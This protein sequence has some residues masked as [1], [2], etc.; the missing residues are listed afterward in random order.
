[1]TTFVDSSAFYAAADAGDRSHARAKSVLGAGER[2]LTSDHVLIET[3]FLIRA[4]GGRRAAE[5]FWREIRGGLAVV[6][7]VLPRD[8]DLAFLIGE[9]FVDQD[10]SIVDR[11]SFAIMERLG[12]TRAASFDDQFAVYRYGARRERAFQVLR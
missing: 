2:L 7:S 4:R 1:V 5:T 8:L 9:V 10:F 12:L 3:W 6:E 11:T